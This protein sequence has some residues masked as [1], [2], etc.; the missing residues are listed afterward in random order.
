MLDAALAY[1]A[2]DQPVFPC[3]PRNK[4]P[5]TPNGFKDATIA[6]AKI[7]AWWRWNPHALIGLRTGF[8]V[9][10]IDLDRKEPDMDGLVTWANWEAEHGPAPKTRSHETPSGGRHLLFRHRSG[11]RNIPLNKLGPGV[12][13]K[14]WG[15]YVIAPPSVLADERA[16]KASGCD[17]VAEAPP[18]L[19]AMLDDYYKQHPHVEVQPKAAP[20]RPYGPYIPDECE[21]MVKADIAA[22]RVRIAT[23][24][25]IAQAEAEAKASR[26]EIEAALSVIP[27]DNYNMWFEIGCALYHELGDAG[28]DLYAAW[29]A[30]SSKYDARK[31][32]AKWRECRKI[33]RYTAG[34]IFYY[35]GQHDSEW[36]AK[37]VYDASPTAEETSVP[38]LIKMTGG[39]AIL[40]RRSA[41]DDN[42]TSRL[43]VREFKVYELEHYQVGPSP[44]LWISY[45]AKGARKWNSIC[46]NPDS[47]SFWAI[48][49]EGA[50]L[51]DSRSDLPTVD[52][53]AVRFTARRKKAL[54]ARLN[55]DFENTIST[56]APK[57]EQPKPAPQQPKPTVVVRG[58]ANSP[59]LADL[60][61]SMRDLRTMT[62]DPLQFVLPN[63]IPEGLTALGGRPKIGKSWLALDTA[64]AVA[65]GGTC[66][67][68]TC[69]QGDVLGLFLEDSKR[70]LQS[71][72]TKLLG[73]QRQEWPD[74]FTYA[75]AWPRMSAGGL[76]LIREWI[77][78]VE[79]PRLI[80]IDILQKFRDLTRARQQAS[81]YEAEY[82]ALSKL[83]EITTEIA[84][85]GI[86]VL[87]HQ[88][89]Q[90]ADDPID[91]I[92][93][94]LGVGGAIDTF[95]ILEKDTLGF[96]LYGRGR[97]LEEFNISLALDEKCRW[98]NRGART[99]DAP[100]S[101][102][103]AN[104][105]AVLAKSGK[106]MTVE[107]IAEAVG[108][109]GDKNIRNLLLKM[110]KD[111]EIERPS[112]GKYCLPSRQDEMP[113]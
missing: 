86:L 107:Q 68:Q 57:T 50:R 113:F 29:S 112:W 88:R 94:T 82:S 95:A 14:A 46:V 69:E 33:T 10:V 55:H 4:S 23:A 2:A 89:K 87:L 98:Q 11:Y 28:Y 24:D 92:S 62:F 67:G 75:T 9:F 32:A 8:K 16:Y 5:L 1:A 40:V 70:R 19:V 45:L 77:K 38:K 79:R 65:T 34:T 37:I 3:D 21:L 59:T 110:E 93:G 7:R 97:D 22:G 61:H 76:L 58:A 74:N 44:C 108:R 20:A 105:I 85:L 42:E 73:A 111:A 25:E 66:L 18:W 71:R 12:E 101:A 17:A 91:T 83:Q 80:I 30:T 104:I 64:I 6:P 36:R 102:E 53:D 109:R 99:G 54:L 106:P 49:H 48:E 52:V 13:V 103:R 56:A 90:G 26:E 51:Y 60:T 47:Y 96:R 78:S 31:C 84:G 35:A 15:G 81:Q 100:A 72:M 43:E 41:S 63:F 39:K 27:S